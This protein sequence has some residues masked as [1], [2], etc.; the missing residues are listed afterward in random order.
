MPD[1]RYEN[2]ARSQT[3]TKTEPDRDDSCRGFLLGRCAFAEPVRNDANLPASVAFERQ[4]L[5]DAFV[6]GRVPLLRLAREVL[7]RHD[8]LL[9]LAAEAL[10]SVVTIEGHGR[11][12]FGVNHQGKHGNL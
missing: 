3:N 10:E 6:V 4:L 1:D 11:V 8:Q 9:D 5:L 2:A 12:V 7:E